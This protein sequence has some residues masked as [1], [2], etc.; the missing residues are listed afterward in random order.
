MRSYYWLI[1]AYVESKSDEVEA[2]SDRDPSKQS[3]ITGAESVMRNLTSELGLAY[4]NIF[5]GVIGF[6]LVLN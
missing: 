4:S 3:T 2:F 1:C 5:L 6:G